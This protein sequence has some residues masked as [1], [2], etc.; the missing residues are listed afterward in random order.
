MRREILIER[1]SVTVELESE[2]VEAPN[3]VVVRAGARL[4]LGCGQCILHRRLLTNGK[5]QIFP[6]NAATIQIVENSARNCSPT[7]RFTQYEKC[8]GSHKRRFFRSGT[9]LF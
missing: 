1:P 4:G 9:Q 3:L 6:S 5:L 8:A 2:V 7:A